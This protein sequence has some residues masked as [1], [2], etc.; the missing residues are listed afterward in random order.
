MEPGALLHSSSL[1]LATNPALRTPFSALAL[2]RV[3]SSRGLPWRQSRNG[4]AFCCRSWNAEEECLCG[5]SIPRADCGRT[6]RSDRTRRT[7]SRDCWCSAALVLRQDRR[8]L[9]SSCV[10]TS[11]VNTEKPSTVGRNALPLLIAVLGILRTSILIPL[12]G[13]DFVHKLNNQSTRRSRPL[14]QS[15]K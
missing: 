5:M 10:W 3:V 11:P 6:F 4:L 15:E 12:L 13:Q 2:G 9:R 1:L 7:R 14:E 8:R